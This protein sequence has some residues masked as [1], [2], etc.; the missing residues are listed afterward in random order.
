MAN[1]DLSDKIFLANLIDPEDKSGTQRMMVNGWL[2]GGIVFVFIVCIIIPI[3][4]AWIQ[5]VPLS[6]YPAV[7]IYW[8]TRIFQIIYDFIFNQFDGNMEQLRHLLNNVING[9]G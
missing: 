4:V 1:L 8:N 9:R 3:I 7:I 6:K 2:I 5:Y